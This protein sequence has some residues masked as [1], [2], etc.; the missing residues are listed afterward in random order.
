LQGRDV[1][2]FVEGDQTV[3]FVIDVEYHVATADRANATCDDFVFYHIAQRCV[4]FF[5]HGC[6][7]SFRVNE[8]AAFV[9]A[10]VE[11]I[12]RAACLNGVKIP[13]V[14]LR[15]PLRRLLQELSFSWCRRWGLS[16][17]YSFRLSYHY[18]WCFN[19]S[20]D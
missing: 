18:S 20:F 16:S 12:V 15:L 4:V 11:V 8:G 13:A 9:D 5:E 14:L 1:A 17:N 7:L 19:S 3:A 10:P 2:E 6:M